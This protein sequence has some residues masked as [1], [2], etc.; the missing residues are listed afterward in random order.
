M[1]SALLSPELL[2]RYT[3]QIKKIT[4][5]WG[6]AGVNLN[7]GKEATNKKG[8]KHLVNYYTR[9]ASEA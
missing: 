5:A 9:R 4:P 8:E 7:K 2:R 6:R 3:H 1:Q